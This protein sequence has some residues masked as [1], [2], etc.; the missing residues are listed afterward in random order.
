MTE[1]DDKRSGDKRSDDWREHLEPKIV[2]E[3][4]IIVDAFCQDP[5]GRTDILVVPDG[6][7]G[8]GYMCAA[9]QILVRDEYLGRVLQLLDEHTE[10]DLKRAEPPRIRRV[11]AG[12]VLLILRG[13]GRSVPEALDLIDADL[14]HGIA[15][16]DHVLTV[17]GGQPTS[18]PA[19]EP[20]PVPDEIEPFPSVCPA[21]AGA[22]VL[23]YLADTG[24]LRGAAVGHPWLAGVRVRDASRD[25]EPYVPPNPAVPGAGAAAIPP[26]TGHGTFVAG[27][28]RCLAPAADVLVTNAFAIAGST[29][30][31]H[32]VRRLD[33]A[34]G[35]GADIFHLTVA[36][37]SR[38]DFPLVAFRQ[39]LRRLQ[40]S[41]GAVCIAPAGNSGIRRP[42]WP[43]AFRD[44]LAVGALGGDWRGRASFSNF[45]GWVDVYAP[46][47]DLIN[48]YTTGSY[49]C[50]IRPYA[51]EVRDF[52]GMARWSGT[53][54]ST[55]IVS[56]LVAARM[57]RTG[58]NARQAA[59]ALLAEARSQAISG[60]GAVL[61]PCCGISARPAGSVWANQQHFQHE[62]ERRCR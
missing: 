10:L 13:S 55:P 16:P 27:V 28:L 25:Y 30:E 51:G 24:R 6:D 46:G 37:V 29:L 33:R 35:L 2:D 62:G 43:A 1:A 58:E 15:T 18:C 34:L 44:V 5:D 8:L 59:A 45:G 9:D 39:W 12:V 11:I 61:L 7:G 54:F 36:C 50:Q 23:V 41:K 38:N 56:G 3:I 20:Q 31:S 49:E 40:D 22:G 26:Y 4:E 42:C 32:L 48:A 19:T 60:V 47:R 21:G 53:S 17:A 57:S 52:Y 14:G